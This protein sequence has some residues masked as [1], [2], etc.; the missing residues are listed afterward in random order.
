MSQIM[1]EGTVQCSVFYISDPGSV[2]LIFIWRISECSGASFVLACIVRGPKTVRPSVQSHLS[3]QN[4]IKR[5]QLE[6]LVPIGL[7][8]HTRRKRLIYNKCRVV[9]LV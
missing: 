3:A 9:W 4:I 2:R 1:I 7:F 5:G 8:S 6:A